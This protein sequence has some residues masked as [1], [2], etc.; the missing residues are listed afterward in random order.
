M[1]LLAL[2][3]LVVVRLLPPHELYRH[4]ANVT[5]LTTYPVLLVGAALLYVYF[6]VT[7]NAGT[8]GLAAAA[9][10]GTAQGLGHVATRI[11]LED[12]VREQP[13]W[14]LLSQVVAAGI[15][16]LLLATRGHWR[17]PD[18]LQVGLGLAIALS[19]GRVVLVER[20]IPSATLDTLMPLLGGLLLFSYGAVALLLVRTF[21]LPDWATWRLALAMGLLGMAQLMTYPAAEPDWRSVLSIGQNVAGATLLVLTTLRL[22]RTL[23]GHVR[24]ERTLLHEVASSVAGITAASRLLTGRARLDREDRERLIELLIAETARIERLMASGHHLAGP[25]PIEE[26]DLDSLVEPLLLAHRIRGRV[27]AWQP[28]HQRV[29]ARRD[30]LVEVLDLLLDN[31]TRHAGSP[32]LAVTVDRRG[33]EVDVTVVDE[34]VGIAPEVAD[35]VLEWGSHGPSSTGQGIGLHVAQRLVT[36]MDGRLRIDSRAGSGTRVTITLPAGE[37]TRADRSA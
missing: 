23:E 19:V 28:N 26:V 1:A 3:A 13:G 6:R 36:G 16:V 31:A 24:H 22:V 32:N 9:V 8:A 34:G 14:L 37:V 18:P 2:P 15:L 21:Q 10:F 25:E 4:A 30:D 29:R 33:D 17:G 5:E 12:E 35:S 27:V 11:M 7:P 20:A